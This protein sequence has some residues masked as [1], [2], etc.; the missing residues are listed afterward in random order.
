MYLMGSFEGK[1]SL[2]FDNEECS[3]LFWKM[4]FLRNLFAWVEQYIEI[5][6]VFTTFYN[7]GLLLGFFLVFCAIR[8][9][10][11]SILVALLLFNESGFIYPKK[12]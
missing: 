8:H 2:E 7:E 4:F 6:S 12:N 10:L 11:R 3:T 9:A 5:D 1:E